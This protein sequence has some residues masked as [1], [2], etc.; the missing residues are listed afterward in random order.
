MKLICCGII[1]PKR[2][3]AEQWA[4][5][6]IAIRLSDPWP[7]WG[8]RRVALISLSDGHRIVKIYPSARCFAATLTEA[9][10]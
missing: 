9:Q 8:G 5:R 6:K 2:E 1:T 10:P 4:E 7:R 3:T